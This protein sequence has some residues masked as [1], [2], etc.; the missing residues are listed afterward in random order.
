MQDADFGTLS[1]TLR[2]D[3]T[4]VL[5]GDGILVT[6]SNIWGN[7]VVLQIYCNKAIPV[8]RVIVDERFPL[9]YRSVRG[10]A[11]GTAD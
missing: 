3:D 5:I 1:L 9:S 6:V 11:F 8:E 2:A 4:S 7:K 10:K